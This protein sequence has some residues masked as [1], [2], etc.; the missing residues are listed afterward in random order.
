M[1]HFFT[2]SKQP[3]TFCFSVDIHAHVI[4]G[5]DDGSPDVETSLQLIDAMH[6]MGINT[7][8]ASPHIAEGAFENTRASIA[9]AY[10]TLA[11]A[12]ARSGRTGVSIKCHAE[13]RIDNMLLE[14]IS[15]AAVPTLP[16]GYALIENSFIQEP[17]NL[18]QLIF[19][20]QVKGYRPILAHP[21]RF[22]YYDMRRLKKLHERVPFQINMLSL[23]GYYGKDICRK[24]IMLAREGLADFLGTD[25]HNMRHIDHLRHYL[26]TSDAR[27]HRAI[28]E[29]IVRNDLFIDAKRQR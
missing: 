1:F 5:I 21:E 4:P 17:W 13:N 20:M 29:P 22:S 18:E 9:T 24:A 26:T 27:R 8:L 16:D 12:L 6:D 11:T 10:E 25:I 2:K 14:N 28:L 7:I 23:A 15:H 19:D 3:I